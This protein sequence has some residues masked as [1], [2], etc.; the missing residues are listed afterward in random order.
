MRE[1]IAKRL[2]RMLPMAV[3]LSSN[4]PVKAAPFGRWTLR[5]KAPRSAP[6]LQR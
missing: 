1:G 6:Y 3:A 5:D 4:I 2:R